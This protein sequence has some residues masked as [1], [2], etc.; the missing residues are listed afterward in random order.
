MPKDTRNLPVISIIGKQ[1]VGKTTLFGLIIPR[2][3]KKG[4]RVGTIK[5]NIPYF[6]ID[7]KG[8]DTYR[9]YEAGADIVS[10]SSPEKLA[11]IKRLN[12][13]TLSIQDI[14][15]N[16][17]SDID[18]VLVEGYKKYQY[19]YIE[20]Y[21]NHLPTKTTDRV[22]KNHINIV[23][24]LP[25]GSPIPTFHKIDLNNVIKFIELKVKQI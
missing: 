25:A 4:Y 3:K 7:Y 15:R 5:Y 24:T 17:Y 2:L 19:P 6:E 14:I 1:N 21:H 18:I 20:I 16:N 12:R 22:Y 9:H 23:S 8:K 11:I 13:H 10:I